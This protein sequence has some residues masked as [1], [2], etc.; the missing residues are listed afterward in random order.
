MLKWYA[1]TV[2]ISER[3]LTSKS[4]SRLKLFALLGMPATPLFALA[5]FGDFSPAVSLIF[6]GLSFLSGIF[7]FVVMLSKFTNRF[8]ARDKYLDEWELQRKHHSMAIGFQVIDYAV[9]LLMAAAFLLIPFSNTTFTI[10]LPQIAMACFSFIVFA[11]YIPLV[12]LLWSTK[13]VNA[14]SNNMSLSDVI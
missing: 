13:P 4:L 2:Q 7:L 8:W 12:F 6:F 14:E 11:V 1:D 5:E 9:C 3:E 10:S